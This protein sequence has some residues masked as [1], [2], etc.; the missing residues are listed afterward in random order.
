[1]KT[2]RLSGLAYEMLLEL[3]KKARK[4][5]EEYVIE[6]IQQQYRGKK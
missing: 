3:C 1:M 5:P 4:K 2:I 6:L